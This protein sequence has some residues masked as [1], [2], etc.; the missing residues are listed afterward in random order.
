[1]MKNVGTSRNFTHC[2]L[3]S[4]GKV[5]VDC[6]SSSFKDMSSSSNRTTSRHSSESKSVT[7]SSRS[8]ES[9]EENTCFGSLM[10]LLRSWNERQLRGVLYLESEVENACLR[11]L[12]K[13]LRSWDERQLSGVL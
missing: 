4:N 7:S 5:F 10:K 6:K 3:L 11:S 13:L 8:L 12:M 9:E 2:L 1:M